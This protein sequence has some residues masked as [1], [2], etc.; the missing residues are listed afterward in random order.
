MVVLARNNMY[1]RNETVY[2]HMIFICSDHHQIIRVR[3]RILSRRRRR[4]LVC[5]YVVGRGDWGRGK[6]ENPPMFVRA[7]GCSKLAM[8]VLRRQDT[9]R[10]RAGR[11]LPILPREIRGPAGW[12]RSKQSGSVIR[13]W[14][15]SVPFRSAHAELRLS[16]S[17]GPRGPDGLAGLGQ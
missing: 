10:G 13:R 4:G 7:A 2:I 3:V 17:P 15:R 5:S 8:A 12:W 9:V 1:K 16:C 11:S 14:F 6:K